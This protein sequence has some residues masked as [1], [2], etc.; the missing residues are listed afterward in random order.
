MMPTRRK[1]KTMALKI[2]QG[3][4]VSDLM[5]VGEEPG[6]PKAH[7]DP[8]GADWNIT[9]A[10]TAWVATLANDSVSRYVN[11]SVSV[12]DD[13]R[14]AGAGT[15]KLHWIT[16]EEPLLRGVLATIQPRVAIDSFARTNKGSIEVRVAQ[17]ADPKQSAAKGLLIVLGI[18][19]AAWYFDKKK[20]RR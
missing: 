3:G 8:N 12:D 14:Q 10:G 9:I 13:D 6:D 11:K 18:I 7:R 19:W 20:G 16:G 2:N 5:E 17:K 15:F 1:G 4:I